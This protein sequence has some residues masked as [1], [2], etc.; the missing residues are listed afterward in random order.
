MPH[1]KLD[2]FN[3][4]GL[5]LDGSLDLTKPQSHQTTQTLNEITSIY[6]NRL[7]T[8]IWQVNSEF[9]FALIMYKHQIN[10]KLQLPKNLNY[11]IN[12]QIIPHKGGHE[13]YVLDLVLA[14][15]GGVE[16]AESIIQNKPRHATG[17]TANYHQY[18]GY[19]FS[20]SGWRNLELKKPYEQRTQYVPISVLKNAVRLFNRFKLNPQ[21]RTQ[22]AK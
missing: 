12:I 8:D 21:A 10:Y 6:V 13:A 4:Q 17:Y 15:V 7:E 2:F 20:Y 19:I 11:P 3:Y 22:E 14:E 5:F 1:T 16:K 18:R 9:E